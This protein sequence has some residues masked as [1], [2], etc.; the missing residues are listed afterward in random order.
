MHEFESRIKATMNIHFSLSKAA[1]L[2][3]FIHRLHCHNNDTAWFIEGGVSPTIF[4]PGGWRMACALGVVV[5]FFYEPGM[6][7]HHSA[8]L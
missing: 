5:A 4:D 7:H 6:H 3:C 2:N 8:F 1:A